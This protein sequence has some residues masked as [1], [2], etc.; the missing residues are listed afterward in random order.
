MIVV[1]GIFGVIGS[2][3]I[4]K[5]GKI[6]ELNTLHLK[7]NYLFSNA[8]RAFRDDESLTTEPIRSELSLIRHQPTDCSGMLGPLERTVISAVGTYRAITLCEED[9]ALADD[10]LS[11]LDR[12][13]AGGLSRK[14]KVL[15]RALSLLFPSPSP[16]RHK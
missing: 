13:E 7:H 16:N 9:L 10:M 15:K 3:E 6:H 4:M 11:T 2:I 14:E 12:F 5:C 8:F 1:S